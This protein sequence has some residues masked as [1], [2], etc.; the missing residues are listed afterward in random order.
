MGFEYFQGYFL[1][2]PKVLEARQLPGNRLATVQLMA[3]LQDPEVDLDELENAIA[4]HV[5]LSYKLLRYVNS[6]YVSI[7]RKVTS[8][9][10]AVLILGVNTVR[11]LA[12]LIALSEIDD[13][14]SELIRIALT[15]ARMCQRLAE[16][17]RED[18]AMFFTVG[19][20]SVLDA[21]LDQPMSDVI[22]N[23]P[24]HPEVK[25]ALLEGSGAAGAALRMTIG[26]ERGDWARAAPPGVPAEAIGTAYRAAVSYADESLKRLRGL[27]G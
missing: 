26:Y 27:D 3:Q 11:D 12:T 1:A 14:P 22:E 8:L 7:S 16:A 5:T 13:K 24:L 25:G 9:R 18:R 17:T 21:L 10:D 6:A 15:R 19:L 2:K 20:L 23:L 4:Q